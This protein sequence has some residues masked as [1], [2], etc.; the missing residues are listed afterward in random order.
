MPQQLTYPGVYIE[1]I[2]S[3][4]RTIIGVSTSVTAFVGRALRGPVDEPIRIASF[5]EFERIFGGLWTESTMSYAVRQYFMNGGVEAII[6]RSFETTGAHD[7]ATIVLTTIDPDA[8]GPGTAGTLTLIASSQGAWA[9]NLQVEV[10]RTHHTDDAKAFDLTVSEVV[11][12]VTVAKEVYYNVTVD[13]SAA[14]YVKKVLEHQSA[15][16]RVVIDGTHVLPAGSP[17]ATSGTPVLVLT[18][19]KANDGLKLDPDTILGTEGAKTGMYALEKTDIFNLL[20]LPPAVPLASAVSGDEYGTDHWDLAHAYCEKRRA[21]VIVNPPESWVSVAAVLDDD[22]EPSVSDMSN[23]TNGAIFFPNVLAPNPLRENQVE[24]YVSCGII[25]GIMARTDAQRGVWKAPAGLDAS[26]LGIQAL[27]L[28]MTDAE[29][30][31][32]N[33]LGINCLRSFPAAG[34]VVWGSRTLKGN[35]RLASEWKYIP[36]RRL[37]LFLEESLY[38]GTQWAVFEPNDEPLWSQLR[39]NVGAFMHQLYRQGA[40]QGRSPREAYFV[41]CDKDTT[42]QNDINQGIVN[43]LIGFAP[44]KPAEF[45]VLKIQQMAGQIES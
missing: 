6:I 31:R 21:F 20:C 37:A 44:L 15:L 29:N 24:E 27:S 35:D 28:K 8:G 11:G 26:I 23:R 3:G 45:V 4:V 9:N 39:L 13:S 14:R 22:T 33:P 18:A 19:N 30:G 2:P 5:G 1:E 42:T 38:R 41:K 10:D 17:A 7:S 16:V 12:G 32:L 25:A 34:N 43:V 36:V 40:F